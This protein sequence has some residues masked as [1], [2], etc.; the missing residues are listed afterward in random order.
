MFRYHVVITLILTLTHFINRHRGKEGEM[1]FFLVGIKSKSLLIL[2]PC[3]FYLANKNVNANVPTRALNST[4]LLLCYPFFPV[5]GNY[6]ENGNVKL[7]F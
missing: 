4:S 2:F 5:Y 1:N 3:R 7:S 6:S